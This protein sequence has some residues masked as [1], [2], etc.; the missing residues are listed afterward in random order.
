MICLCTKVFKNIRVKI[1]DVMSV[2]ISS[3]QNVLWMLHNKTLLICYR[4]C[5]SGVFRNF[6]SIRIKSRACIL[7][8]VIIIENLKYNAEEIPCGQC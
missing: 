1:E 3:I 7:V 4:E 6:I 8:L 5:I 2:V